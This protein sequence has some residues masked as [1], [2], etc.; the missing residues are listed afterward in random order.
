MSSG[1]ANE[2]VSEFCAETDWRTFPGSPFPGP[3]WKSGPLATLESI[4]RCP[5]RFWYLFPSGIGVIVRSIDDGGSAAGRRSRSDQPFGTRIG[6]TAYQASNSRDLFGDDASRF[7]R[8]NAD[9][10]TR[11]MIDRMKDHFEGR[12]ARHWL[13]L[14]KKR[15]PMVFVT[16]RL[17]KSKRKGG[18]SRE[19]HRDASVMTQVKVEMAG[20]SEIEWTDATWNP[21]RGLRHDLTRMHQLLC[22]ANGSQIR[23][24]WR[25]IL[26]RRYSKERRSLCLDWRARINEKALEAPLE[27]KRPKKIFVN[28]MSDLFQDVVSA[29]DLARVW[30]VMA[31]APQHRFQVLTKRP[32]RMRAFFSRE[33]WPP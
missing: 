18:G 21:D 1:R 33:G 5:Y 29:D 26:S 22:H 8:L 13:P 12:R 7:V 14:G 23:G 3:L 2:A 6:A 16:V 25:T 4:A 11:F 32:D 15:R 19:P 30:D 10:V 31:R 20:P 28:S 17:G 24:D 27:W 9:E